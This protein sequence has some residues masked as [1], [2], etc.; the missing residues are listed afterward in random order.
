VTGVVAFAAAVFTLWMAWRGYRRGAARALLGWLPAFAAVVVLLVA[1]RVAFQWPTHLALVSVAGV[2]AGIGMFVA[3]ALVVRSKA[4]A[5]DARRSAAPADTRRSPWRGADRV[6]GA[7]LGVVNAAALCLGVACVVSL[8]LFAVS[9]AADPPPAA[10]RPEPRPEWVGALGQTCSDLAHLADVGVLRH[11]PGLR[12]YG[13]EVKALVTVLNA[14]RDQL[15]RLAEERSFADLVAV[16]AV[17][18]ALTDDEYLALVNEARDG[19][20]SGLSRLARDP[21]TTGLF[22]CPEFRAVIK[23]LKPSLLAADLERIAADG[24]D[25]EPTPEAHAEDKGK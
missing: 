11:V 7:V 6:L 24:A 15:D 4:R 20:L 21:I 19:N 14:P 16:P 23:G 9:F 17:Q 8:A 13:R 10:D 12:T 3:V 2:V 18:K 25:K 5:I 22:E 1:A